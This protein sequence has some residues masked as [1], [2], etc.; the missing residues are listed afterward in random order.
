MPRSV[1]TSCDEKAER[2]PESF[3]DQA[4]ASAR[5][6]PAMQF[7]MQVSPLDCTGCGNCVDVCPAKEKALA[8]E[9]LAP[10]RRLRRRTGSSLRRMPGGRFREPRTRRTV[11]E[12]PVP[13][14]A[15]RVLRRLRRLRRDPVRQAGYPA[16]RR[17]HDRCQRDG[18]L[19]H[20]WRLRSDLSRTPPTIRVRARLGRTPCSRTTLSSASA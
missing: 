20:L 2:A 9:P 15:V 10:S 12:Q 3:V 4:R 7:R 1:R 16:V 5:S 14:A 8:M 11:K 18:L 19:L 6:S 13:Q 17:P